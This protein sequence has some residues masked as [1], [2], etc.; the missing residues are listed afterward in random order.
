MPHFS[1]KKPHKFSVNFAEIE[2]KAASETPFWEVQR[3]EALN[4]ITTFFRTWQTLWTGTKQ[5]LGDLHLSEESLR[6]LHYY[7]NEQQQTILN[8][9]ASILVAWEKDSG[10]DF[11]TAVLSLAKELRPSLMHFETDLDDN[12]ALN[13][14]QLQLLKHFTAREAAYLKSAVEDLQRLSWHKFEFGDKALSHS[15]AVAL[16]KEQLHLTY[17]E[18]LDTSTEP[19][20][21]NGFLPELLQDSVDFGLQ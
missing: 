20:F 4:I 11:S 14:A 17:F 13:Q 8:L 3:S 21:K 12:F 2:A 15:N 10:A 5:A 19:T 7:E 9:L 6:R 16:I 18:F 1:F